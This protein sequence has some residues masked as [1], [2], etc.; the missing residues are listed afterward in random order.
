[1][2]YGS[3]HLKTVVVIT[4]P[5]FK[6]KLMNNLF[7]L[8][9]M[10]NTICPKCRVI[11]FFIVL[12]FYLAPPLLGG[13]LG[14]CQ[15]ILDLLSS[16]PSYSTLL[17][18]P[19]L[20]SLS[21]YNKKIHVAAPQPICAYNKIGPHNKNILEI[22]FGSLLGKGYAERKN[23]GTC[24]TFYQEA[25]HVKYLLLLHNQ[26]ATLGYCNQYPPKIGKKLGK[27]GKIYRTI[28]FSTLIFTSF[29]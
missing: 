9:K 12:F 22:I 2:S 27:K 21:K 8:K 23:N 24:I 5:F 25:I 29:D 11:S 16:T 4:G 3:K 15:S 13:A 18:T 7:F 28:K 10:Y 26:L 19:L 14:I 1:M 20:H 17:A 6:K